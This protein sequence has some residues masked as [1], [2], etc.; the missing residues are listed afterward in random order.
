[1]RSR[2]FSGQGSQCLAHPPADEAVLKLGRANTSCKECLPLI[3]TSGT[4]LN[5]V[6]H[7][8]KPDEVV[9]YFMPTGSGPCRF[10]Q[11]Y[12]FMED[13]IKRLQLPDVAVFSLTSENS[14]VGLGVDFQRK[15]W[16]AIVVSDLM[17]DI[18][19]MLLA[20]AMDVEAALETFQ[21][22]WRKIL[23]TL[24]ADNFSRLEA[25]LDHA[26]E[27]FSRIRTRRSLPEVP[28]VLLT[29][30]IFVRRDALSRQFIT[31]RLAAN[32]IATLCSPIAE[33]ILYS[34]YLRDNGLVHYDL[35]KMDKLE[36]MLKKKFMAQYEKRIK[37]IL[38]RSGLI[39]AAP[40]SIESIIHHAANYLS[41]DLTGEAILTVG[42]S[43]AEIAAAVC[44]VI[45][46]GPFGCMPNR[47]SESIL[48]DAMKREDVLSSCAA[49]KPLLRAI[50]DV[51]DLPFIAIESD[52][53]PFPQ[54]IDAK[55]EA[56]C[57]RAER[58]HRKMREVSS[59]LKK[60]DSKKRI[61]AGGPD[62]RQIG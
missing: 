16:W 30:E 34:D 46:I 3:L 51:D 41:P 49:D 17:E 58:L 40:L 54:L 35:S 13:L 22:E 33:W 5:Y 59:Q 48:A 8:K 31:E 14:Y 55:L 29:G 2:Q 38:N 44:G 57:L 52:G 43:I 1:M 15:G 50:A 36:F 62:V 24:E 23:K 12:I 19:A 37:A 28:L 7:R 53:S 61:W 27:A 45:A 21:G 56:F 25:R 9:V 42:S 32:G 20:N 10:G 18:R 47:L 4:L 6:F 11:Y 39:H 26:A 60:R